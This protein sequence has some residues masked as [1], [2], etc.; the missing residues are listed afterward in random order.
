MAK[1]SSLGS[2]SFHGV[3]GHT[4]AKVRKFDLSIIRRLS[5]DI[6]VLELGS[7][8]LTRLPAQTVG[9]ELETLV[10][11]LHDEVN[12]KS[13]VVCQ[14][15]RWHALGCTVY[16]IK[17]TKLHLYLKAVLE[18]IPF[19]LYWRHRGFWNSRKNT[20]L[21]DGVH[22]NALGNFKLFRSIRGAVIKAVGLVGL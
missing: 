6:M 20:Y 19:C 13:I 5:P 8:D 17:V 15:I 22:L 7:N 9:S 10:R 3:G 18:P 21:P 11:Y 1:L 2:I 4:I 12:V 14:V 16:N